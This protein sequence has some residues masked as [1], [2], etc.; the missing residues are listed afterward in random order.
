MSRNCIR[1]DT[2]ESCQRNINNELINIFNR[3]MRAKAR[4][5]EPLEDTHAVLTILDI[6][7]DDLSQLINNLRQDKD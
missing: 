7:Q 4:L 6:L 2:P 5:P 1:G 3:S